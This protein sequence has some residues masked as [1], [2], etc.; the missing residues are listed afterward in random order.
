MTIKLI[1]ETD[2]LFFYIE[3]FEGEPIVIFKD[4]KTDKVFFNLDDVARALGYDGPDDMMS[5]DGI[6]DGLNEIKQETGE[7]PIMAFDQL[8]DAHQKDLLGFANNIE[9]IVS[10]VVM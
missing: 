7:F 1:K 8:S 10:N 2:N 5:N 6:L 4:K 3:W 9:F